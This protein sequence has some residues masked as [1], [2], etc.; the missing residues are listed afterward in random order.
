MKKACFLLSLALSTSLF[1]AVLQTE[2]KGFLEKEKGGLILHLKGTPYEMGYQHGTLLKSAI[3]KMVAN[4]I[5]GKKE[6]LVEERF[7]AF[8]KVFPL[9]LKYIPNEYLKE[10]EG[11]AEGSS[12]PLEKIQLLNLF[13]EMFHCSGVIALPRAT[14]DQDLYHVRVLDYKAAQGIEKAAV[15]MAIEPENRHSFVNVSYPGFVGSVTGMNDQKISLGEI[16]GLGYGRWE[17]CPMSFLMRYVLERAS[18]LKEAKQLFEETKRTCEYYYLMADGKSKTAVA[19]YATPSQVSF[20]EPGTSY[21][22]IQSNEGIFE[23]EKEVI[24]PFSFKSFEGMTLLLDGK[25]QVRGLFLEQPK[26]S[27]LLT[28]YPKPERFPVLYSRFMKDFGHLTLVKMQELVKPPVT[29]DSNLHNAIFQPCK[30]QISVAH[31]KDG[32][33]ASLEEYKTYSWD[34]LFSN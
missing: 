19:L 26:E 7:K 6:G 15:L 20:I 16:G 24:S 12:M 25:E 33:P 28:G 22:L 27:L 14:E 29:C 10:M 31:A 21:T 30:L 23:K 17:G 2:G 34:E 11:L 5:D 8:Q 9:V 32:S 13:P 4:F 1:S 18:S 3:Q